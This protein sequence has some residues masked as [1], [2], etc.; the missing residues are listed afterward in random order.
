MFPARRCGALFG[1]SGTTSSLMVFPPAALFRHLFS[2][3]AS[4]LLSR[5]N[6]QE[7]KKW[8]WIDGS[9]RIPKKPRAVRSR[10]RGRG[11]TGSFRALIVPTVAER[12]VPPDEWRQERRRSFRPDKEIHPLTLAS[13]EDSPALCSG[14]L[15]RDPPGLSPQPQESQ[16]MTDLARAPMSGAGDGNRT[17]V[18]SLGS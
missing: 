1:T 3:M 14:F 12:S 16:S 8:E 4:V 5:F 15:L 2:G 6:L 13:V 9:F 7:G 17:R 18:L 10:K 11:R